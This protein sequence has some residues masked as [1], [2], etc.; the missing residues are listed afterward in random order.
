[1]SRETRHILRGR[2]ESLIFENPPKPAN[3]PASFLDTVLSKSFF[4][5]WLF[6][7]ALL[8]LISSS[9][10][11]APAGISELLKLNFSATHG[12]ALAAAGDIESHR[13]AFAYRESFIEKTEIII[14]A[15]EVRSPI[16]SPASNDLAT[17]NRVLAEGVVHY[18]G[19]AAPGEVGN[20]FMF[21]HSANL[22]A[23][24]NKAYTVFNRVK[25][26]KPG[27]A[28]KI[29]DKNREYLYLV[30]SI[31][32]KKADDAKIDFV[33][34]KRRLTIST[35]K[36]I[37][38]SDEYRYVVEAEFLRSYPVRTLAVK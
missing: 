6:S 18:P 34:E 12:A 3:T 5:K 26:L 16:V 24:R 14:P 4:A 22:P 23:A 38:P 8:L 17:L 29:R 32:V 7:S 35:C 36:L 20:V 27:D 15:I 11:L 1:M 13:A 2:A 31:S 33:S 9:L 37:G 10:G 30:S 28:I 19:S 25:E 21:G